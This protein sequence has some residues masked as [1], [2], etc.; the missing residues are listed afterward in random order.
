[1][2]NMNYMECHIPEQ[3]LFK[4]TIEVT[5]C[6]NIAFDRKIFGENNKETEDSMVVT[7]RVPKPL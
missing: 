1:M 5:K 6:L 3:I 7:S 4:D 2:N